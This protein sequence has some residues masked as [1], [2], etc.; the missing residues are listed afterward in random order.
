MRASMTGRRRAAQ[1]RDAMVGDKPAGGQPS[2]LVRPQPEDARL[3]EEVAAIDQDGA[4]RSM[5]AVREKA[6][7]LYLNAQEILTLMTIGAHPRWLALGYL[8]NQSMLE[9][10]DE[11]AGVDVDEEVGAIVVRTRR[12]T[13]YER[14]L[15]R[16]TRTSGCA[17]GT[18]FG[19]VMEDFDAVRLDES[20]RVYASWLHR[21]TREIAAMPSLYLKA[22]AIHGCVLCRGDAPLVYV[23]DVG[24]H[25][26]V[27]AIAG[28]MWEAGI[29]PEDKIFYTTGRLTSEMIL[30]TARMGIPILVSRSG[31]TSW[32]VAL[33]RRVGMTLIARAKGQRFLV[34]A[35][36]ERVVWDTAT[37]A[38]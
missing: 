14:K 11:V 24:R 22:G 37:S 1:P 6:Y 8:R 27:D 25:N 21:L 34:L 15:Q 32:G 23:E 29:A 4:E 19:D 30:K 38:R 33:A 36:A 18:M 3:F 28:H 20:A 10:D 5:H 17:V 2:L 7:T 13:N 12:H 26:A 35:G 16:R 9:D 31:F